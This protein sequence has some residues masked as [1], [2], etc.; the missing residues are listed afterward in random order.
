VIQGPFLPLRAFALPATHCFKERWL[1]AE[2]L[3]ASKLATLISSSRA[4]QWIPS[5]P[6]IKRQVRRSLGVAFANLGYQ[7]TG[8]LIVRPS[9]RSTD[10]VFRLIATCLANASR[11]LTMKELIPALQQSLSMFLDQRLNAVD[12]LLAKTTFV[13]QLNR[14]EPELGLENPRARRECEAVR[15]RR[16]RRRKTD[17]ALR[18]VRLA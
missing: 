8:T 17:T 3:P 14:I 18:E 11:T 6:P 1:S 12:F 13:C 4:G 2:G 5:P 7:A 15:H 9:A 10:S 16:Q